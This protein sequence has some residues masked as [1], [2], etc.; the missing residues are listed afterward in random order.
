MKVLLTS[1]GTKVPIDSV[2]HIGNMSRGT[3]ARAIGMQGL[4]S[5][6]NLDFVYA[7]GTRAPHLLDVDIFD[8]L[9]DTTDRI[10]EIKRIVQPSRYASW[11]YKDFNSYQSLLDARIEA[12]QPDVIVLAAAV[13]DYGTV[14]F[15][16]KIRSKDNLTIH[17][18][19][20]PK[21]ISGIRK[22]APNALL[23]GFKLLVDSTEDE[24]VAEAALSI[25]NNDCDLVVANDL[26]DIRRA[27]HKVC[28]VTLEDTEVYT[29]NCPAAVVKKINEM[30]GKQ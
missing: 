5:G 7:D 23:V 4:D 3:F 20:L 12:F 6:W 21:I 9:Y 28:L 17:L 24:L 15:D 11:V 18:E 2:R 1:G 10:L 13:S 19:P 27:E 14:P 26:S 30:M 8:E 16:G 29:E 25:I 22:R